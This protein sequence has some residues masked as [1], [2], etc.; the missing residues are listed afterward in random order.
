MVR[1]LKNNFEIC[2][3]MGHQTGMPGFLIRAALL[4]LGSSIKSNT[5]YD[6]L[7]VSP[8]EK[9][10]E[11][12]I[13]AFFISAKDDKISLPSRVKKLYEAYGS[14][15]K[16]L[17]VVEGEHAHD[18]PH[19]TILKGIEFLKNSR[20][21]HLDRS[22]INTNRDEGEAQLISTSLKPFLLSKKHEQASKNLGDLDTLSE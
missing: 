20:K 11:C 21:Y 15:I 8:I 3:L 22:I 9:A 12:T 16:E 17:E 1:K 7:G 19:E 6:V 14:D 4:P 2:D 5:G 18:R 13:P 10:P